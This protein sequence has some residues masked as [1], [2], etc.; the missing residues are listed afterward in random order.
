MIC[1][2][3]IEYEPMESFVKGSWITFSCRKFQAPLYS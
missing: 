2:N 1:N 3:I